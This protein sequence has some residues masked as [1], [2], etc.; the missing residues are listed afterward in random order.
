MSWLCLFYTMWVDWACFKTCELIGLV[1]HYV[2]WLG[3]L[4][5]MWFDWACF[6]LCEACF[7]FEFLTDQRCKNNSKFQRDFR[8]LPLQCELKV[9]K[10]ENSSVYC[11]LLSAMN[12]STFFFL[13][14][15]WYH[16]C[17]ALRRSR[18]RLPAEPKSGFRGALSLVRTT[19]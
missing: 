1:L 18:V 2:S 7:F 4:Y 9:L 16:I 14:L 13:L 19:E 8:S 12:Y 6:I 15:F 17:I 11:L 5:T 3:L 10:S